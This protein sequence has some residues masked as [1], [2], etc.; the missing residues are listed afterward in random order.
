MFSLLFLSIIG[1]I[2]AQETIVDVADCPAGYFCLAR[3]ILPIPCPPGT[4]SNAGAVQCQQCQLGYYSTTGGSSYCTICEPGHSCGAAE[5]P[6]EACPLG[7]YN[8][9]LGQVECTPC[10]SGTYT[11]ATASVECTLCP[12]GSFCSDAAVLPDLCPTGI[13]IQARSRTKGKYGA[14]NIRLLSGQE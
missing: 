9:K 3:G 6:P 11:P 2:L 14:A 13:N 10:D 4:W 12:A 5:L 1:C 8:D 7:F